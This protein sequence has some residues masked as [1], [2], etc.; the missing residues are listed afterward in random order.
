MSR[1][2]LGP[3][4]CAIWTGQAPVCTQGILGFCA[5]TCVLS[6]VYTHMLSHALMCARIMSTYRITRV[7]TQV[8]LVSHMNS[9]MLPP[10]T[11][12]HGRVLPHS[13]THDHMLSHMAQ[14]T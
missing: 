4:L 7:H 10:G 9:H 6:Q 14:C 1:R 11:H 13:C 3:T 8:T 2:S 5:P 12:V